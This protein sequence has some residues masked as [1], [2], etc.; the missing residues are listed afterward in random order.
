MGRVVDVAVCVERGYAGAMFALFVLPEGFVVAALVFP[1][2][3]HVRK[4]GGAAVRAKDGA[5]VFVLAVFVAVLVVGAVAMVW[6]R[7]YELYQSC[8]GL[9]T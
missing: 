9:T 4:E 7:D 5:D 1:V 8:A 2:S 3:F 6:P